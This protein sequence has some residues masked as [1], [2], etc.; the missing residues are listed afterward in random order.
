MKYL[1]SKKKKYLRGVAH[2]LKPVAFVGQKGVTD[3]LVQ[4]IDE[5]LTSHELIKVKFIEFREKEKKK[6]ITGAV[7][8][9]TGC[10]L[11]GMIGHTVILYR[12]CADKKKRKIKVPGVEGDV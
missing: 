7:E 11:I 10:E 1:K 5:A 6:E 12:P 4:A 3:T 2:K 9:R 8:K